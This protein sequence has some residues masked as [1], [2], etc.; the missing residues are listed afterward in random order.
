MHSVVYYAEVS[1]GLQVLNVAYATVAGLCTFIGATGYY[2]Y[3]TA[4]KDLITF[5]LPAVCM[6]A[7][8]PMALQL[9]AGVHQ[10]A[11]VPVDAHPGHL[12][13]YH[14]RHAGYPLRKASSSQP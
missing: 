10:S 7:T 3:G 4:A 12:L 2:M 1:I 9:H 14:A 5:N 8:L 11:I 6:T 13:S